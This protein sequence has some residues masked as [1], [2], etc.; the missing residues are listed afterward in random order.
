MEWEGPFEE[1]VGGRLLIGSE[2]ER[3]E[4]GEV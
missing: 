4:V 1:R 2:F 3:L